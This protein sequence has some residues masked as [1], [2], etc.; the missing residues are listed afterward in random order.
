MP[1]WK[2]NMIN[3]QDIKNWLCRSSQLIKEKIV[4]KKYI[5]AFRM[6][7][8][9]NNEKYMYKLLDKVNVY[10]IFSCNKFDTLL[11]E[12]IIENKNYKFATKLITEYNIPLKF[13]HYTDNYFTNKE[14]Y[15]NKN[16][17]KYLYRSQIPSEFIELLNI[18]AKLQE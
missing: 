13:A 6:A 2:N 8:V 1:N 18:V 7:C 5:E 11:Y 15:T 17:V 10:E 9:H 14:I 3:E 4:K 16:V 12:I